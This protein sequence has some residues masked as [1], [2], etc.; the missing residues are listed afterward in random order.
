M[1]NL[2]ATIAERASSSAN[3]C[4]SML[5]CSAPIARRASSNAYDMTSIPCSNGL[6]NLWAAGTASGAAPDLST[7]SSKTM[8]LR[9]DEGALRC[10][11]RN[12]SDRG[13]VVQGS[14]RAAVRYCHPGCLLQRLPDV[15]ERCM[16]NAVRRTLRRHSD[17]LAIG[18]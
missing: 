7:S 6:W 17:D 12:D 8:R 11:C 16:L 5:N 1:L 13:S 2:S 3:W 9:V 14:S 4:P 18:L 15:Q 10:D